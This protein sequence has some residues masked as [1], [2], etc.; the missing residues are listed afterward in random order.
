MFCHRPLA[1]PARD[2]L[3]TYHGLAD[4]VPGANLYEPGR[5]HSHE[6]VNETVKPI[7]VSM[8]EESTKL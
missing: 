7:N 8:L 2:V 6:L 1:V 4:D 5:V 3:V